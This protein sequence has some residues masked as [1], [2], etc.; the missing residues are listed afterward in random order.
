MTIIIAAVVLIGAACVA[1]VGLL[2]YL[3][4]RDHDLIWRPGVPFP[5]PRHARARFTISDF[6]AQVGPNGASGRVIDTHGATCGNV[7]I[8]QIETCQD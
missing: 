6:S 7:E 3:L 2:A 1:E 8:G 5:D 4:R